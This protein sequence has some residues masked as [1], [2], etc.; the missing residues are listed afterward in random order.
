MMMECEILNE[1]L[2]DGIADINS[3]IH[4]ERSTL[5]EHLQKWSGPKCVDQYTHLRTAGSDAIR[6]EWKPAGQNCLDGAKFWSHKEC[7]PFVPLWLPVT[8]MYEHSPVFNLTCGESNNTMLPCAQN[9]CQ[10]LQ[11]FCFCPLPNRIAH[12]YELDDKGIMSAQSNNSTQNAANSTCFSLNILQSF[13]FPS[14]LLL[15][16]A[17]LEQSY[18]LWL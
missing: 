10:H 1:N 17:G 16:R 13:S 3:L 7:L 8:V 5:K 18:G 11:Y 2:V 9:N 14:D 12:I 15:M 4:F 6:I